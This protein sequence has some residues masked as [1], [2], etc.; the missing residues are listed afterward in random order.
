MTG[1]GRSDFETALERIEAYLKT[2]LLPD[3]KGITLFSRAGEEALFLPLQFRVPLPN[4]VAV[5][6]RNC[7]AVLQNA[8]RHSWA[9]SCAHVRFLAAGCMPYRTERSARRWA[10]PASAVERGEPRRMRSSSVTL[11]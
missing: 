6:T 3:A 1:R 5:D 4:W 11:S 2:G 9:I 10:A 7:V 8:Q